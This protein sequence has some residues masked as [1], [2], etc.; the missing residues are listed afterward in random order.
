MSW[1]TFIIAWLLADFI[2][3]V[4]HWLEDRY[5]NPEWP[6]IG[7]LVVEPN[8]RH[9]TDPKAMLAGSYWS[10]NYTTI[11]PAMS[12]AVVCWVLGGPAWLTLAFVFSSQA[13]QIHGWTHGKPPKI[14]AFLQR[15][16]LFIR[17]T[18]HHKHHRQPF[19]TDYCTISPVLNPV[20]S[21]TRFWTAAEWVLSL[22]GI[23][24]FL[25]RA[26]YLV[27]PAPR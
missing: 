9:H 6:V 4:F 15:I 20:L 13:N 26:D 3:G 8:I 21:I 1:T 25:A 7:K 22:I 19:N 10:R 24:P 11:I 14:V 18:D 17:A 5:G 27:T 2:S 12:A 23:H 16:N